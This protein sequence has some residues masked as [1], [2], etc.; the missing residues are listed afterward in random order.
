[1]TSTTT[2]AAALATEKQISFYRSLVAQ[3][4]PGD[5]GTIDFVVSTFAKVDR[6]KA[7]RLITAAIEA[8]REA[9]KTAP[10]ARP[11]APAAPAPAAAPASAQ[12][13]SIHPGI[14]TVV[15]EA[16]RRTFQVEIQAS[17]AA[18]APGKTVLS[19]LNGP[20]NTSNYRGFAFLV[21][22]T[23]RPWNAYKD[24]ADLLG[25]AAALVANPEAALVA[26]HCA[27]CNRVL[28]TPASIAAGLGPECSKRGLR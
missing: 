26:K 11:V 12:L 3:I 14:Y 5:A 2:P 16:G 6:A 20:D 13:A 21:G 4:F 28:T 15:T 27:R 17:D 24:A 1:M 7:S 22:S 19:F 18:F 9:S 23:L 10:V 8:A 25:F